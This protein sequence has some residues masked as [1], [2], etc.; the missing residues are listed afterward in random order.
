M[1]APHAPFPK[2]HS[3]PV[4]VELRQIY[5]PDD[6]AASDPTGELRRKM[7]ELGERIERN[8]AST[9]LSA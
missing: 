1:A 8:S 2:I 5:E 7:R 3:H 6:L 4:T 9:G